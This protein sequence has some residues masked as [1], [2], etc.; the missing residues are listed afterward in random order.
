MSSFFFLGVMKF[1][2]DYQHKCTDED[3]KGDTLAFLKAEVKTQKKQ[4]KHIKKRSLWS[5]SLEEIMEMLV[6]MMQFLNSEITMSLALK[7]YGH[8]PLVGHKNNHQR[9]GPVG[10]ALHYVNIMLQIDTSLQF[11]SL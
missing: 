7:V 8:R 3:Q 5:R 2:Q 10:L 11:C 6:D 4:I 1:E 9:L